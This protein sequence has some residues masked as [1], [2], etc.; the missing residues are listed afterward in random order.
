[1]NSLRKNLLLK[2]KNDFQTLSKQSKYKARIYKSI[3]LL[4][5]IVI[6]LGGAIITYL[7][8]PK[9][10]ESSKETVILNLIR[11]FGII[12]T[13]FTAL[14]SLFTFEKR[15]LS[16]IQIHT[17]CETILPEIEEKIDSDVSENENVREYIKSLYKDL[18]QLS[19]ASFTDAVSHRFIK[20]T[21]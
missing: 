14:A 2:A 9:N 4:I 10:E 12:I 20:N 5:K 13:T 15:S 18:A 17:K 7:S 3:D 19:L 8:D 11:A 1:M 16:H 21:E 6:S